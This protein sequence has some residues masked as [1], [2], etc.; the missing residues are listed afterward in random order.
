MISPYSP[1]AA[2][3]KPVLLY[4]NMGM[5][6]KTAAIEQYLL[7]RIGSGACP[8]RTRLPSQQ[9]LMR[10]FDCSRVTVLR[11][12]RR[13]ERTG[14]LYAQKGRGTFVRQSAPSPG[15]I[16]EIVVIG[17]YL[18]NSPFYPFAEMLAQVN[19]GGLPLRLLYTR[20]LP[21]S[22]ETRFHPGQAIL[23]MLP[24]ESQRIYM[25]YLRDKG[26]PQ[27]LIN[28]RYDGY[29]HIATDIRPGMEEGV[30]WLKAA[31][32]GNLALI[33]HSPGS[34][35]PYQ[36]ERIIAFYEACFANGLR[37]LPENNFRY[38][39]DAPQATFD[40]L[41]RRLFTPA[42]AP[43][44][45]LDLDHELAVPLILRATKE[46][47]VL[48]K[49][50]FLLTMDHGIPDL[51]RQNGVAVLEQPMEAFRTGIEEWLRHIA[52]SREP[53]SRTPPLALQ[54]PP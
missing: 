38:A 33:C 35:R 46:G 48:G 24:R 34:G 2:A 42:T 1:L 9:Q 3:G 16:T 50:Y 29:D 39:D 18:E 5:F 20:D 13:L 12:L 52:T 21:R 40:R 8:P 32:G 43:V 31:A 49:D 37:L 44:G 27:L 36:A 14:V 45:I 23:W 51:S 26:L 30:R 15:G 53:F 22:L 47:R 28:R 25:E 54:P 19:T 4:Y 41:A 17:D 10:Q 6:T 11:A 7:E